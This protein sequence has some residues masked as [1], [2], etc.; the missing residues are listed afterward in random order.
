MFRTIAILGAVGLTMAGCSSH[1]PKTMAQFEPQYCYQSNTIKTKN[2]NT[3]SSEGLTE[4]TDNPANKHFL[5]YSGL[6]KDCREHWYSIIL[7]GKEE[8][9][10]GY[11]CQKIDGTW[12]V[13]NHPYN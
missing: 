1:T 7:K 8:K 13:V 10:R 5:A 11:I 4:C 9:R 2:G 12:E 6:A 3:V